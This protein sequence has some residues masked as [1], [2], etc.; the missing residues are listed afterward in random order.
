MCKHR[1]HEQLIRWNECA[2]LRVH[3][4]LHRPHPMA[5]ERGQR[6][7]N[8][9]AIES[10]TCRAQVSVSLNAPVSVSSTPLLLP[11]LFPVPLTLH[12]RH[13]RCPTRGGSSFP[14]PVTSRESASYFP[15]RPFPPMSASSYGTK[16]ERS[17]VHAKHELFELPPSCL[18]STRLRT[19][20]MRAI[21][22]SHLTS[23]LISEHNPPLDSHLA[24]VISSH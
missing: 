9:A 23:S 11:L 16:N 5:D 7:V 14:S 19:S 10:S 1:V 22:T 12:C 18:C 20:L 21:L 8:A 13:C 6:K 2:V 24:A 4:E 3:S 15:A 17:A